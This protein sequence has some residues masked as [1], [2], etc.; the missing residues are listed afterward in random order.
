MFLCTWS[1]EA[2]PQSLLAILRIKLAVDETSSQ[3][4]NPGT[5]LHIHSNSGIT[6]STKPKVLLYDWEEVSGL[7][8]VT[9]RHWNWRFNLFEDVD[10]RH[11]DIL[12]TNRL[13]RRD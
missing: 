2:S 12:T 1:T 4:G 13:G 7:H 11:S 3:R 6:H 8:N 9:T 5:V 10:Q